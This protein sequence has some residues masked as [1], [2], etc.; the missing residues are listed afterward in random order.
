MS[1]DAKH[2]PPVEFFWL[3]LTEVCDTTGYW[4]V[5]V[6]AWADV[7]RVEWF[8]DSTGCAYLRD[9]SSRQFEFATIREREDPFYIIENCIKNA[10]RRER[11]KERVAKALINRKGAKDGEALPE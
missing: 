1:E 2:R 9:G 11:Q 8:T 10:K 4:K 7:F 3:I 5:N 6:I